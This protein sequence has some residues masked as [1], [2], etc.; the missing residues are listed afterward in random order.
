MESGKIIKCMEKE[1]S[2]GMMVDPM[3]ESTKT[4]KNMASVS[5]SKLLIYSNR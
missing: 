4:I 1:K 3:M 2:N 5:I